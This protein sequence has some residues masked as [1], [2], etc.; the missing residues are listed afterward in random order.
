MIF[1]YSSRKR[2]S[3]AF[4]AGSSVT[5][6][7][8]L[9]WPVADAVKVALP[10]PEESAVTVTGCAVFQFDGVKVSEDPLVTD[11]P[12][13]PAVRATPTVTFALGCVDSFTENVPDLPCCTPSWLGEATTAGPEATVMPTGVEAADAPRLSYAF[14][15]SE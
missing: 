7:V 11:K 8:A 14:A 5:V 15:T 3:Y 1:P 10:V 2:A 6:T 12:V 9:V 4:D 13:L